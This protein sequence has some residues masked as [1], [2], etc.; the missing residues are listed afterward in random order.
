MAASASIDPSIGTAAQF[1]NIDLLLV[2]RFD[3]GP[4]LGAVGDGLF[5]LHEQA[6]LNKDKCLPS[7]WLHLALTLRVRSRGS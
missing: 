4:L 5:V 2:G 3:R 1:L 7:K 6:L